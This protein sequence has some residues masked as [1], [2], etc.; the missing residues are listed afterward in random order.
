MISHARATYQI[1]CNETPRD[2]VSGGAMRAGDE[3]RRS[4]L[5]LSLDPPTNPKRPPEY[6]TNVSMCGLYV[7]AVAGRGRRA[8]GRLTRL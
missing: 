2:P 1:A 8:T 7:T 4:P 3:L 5:V 6:V